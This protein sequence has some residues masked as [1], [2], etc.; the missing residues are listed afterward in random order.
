[1]A[2]PPPQTQEFVDRLTS[3]AV[4]CREELARSSQSIQEIDL[5]I[6]Q[7]QQE[8]DRLSQRE[9]QTNARLRDL[10]ASLE[11]YSR[12]EIRDAYLAAHETQMRLFMMRSQI[13]QLESRRESIDQQQEKLRILLDLAEINREQ[14]EEEL[15]GGEDRT[16]ILPGTQI[17][18]SN[19]D[20][21]AEIVEAREQ[22]RIRI[23]KQLTDGPA[24]VLANV[25]LRAQILARVAER[26]PDQLPAEIEDLSKLV[27]DSLTDVRR[28]IF[29]TRP[30]MLDELGLVQT[31]RRYSADYAREYGA[32]INVD[33]PEHQDEGLQRHA[34]VVLFRLIQQAVVALVQ[35]GAGTQMQINI[36]DEG[37]Q[38]VVRI[39]ATSLGAGASNR[40][41]HFVEDEYINDNLELIGATIQRESI[42]GGER[43]S[44]IMPLAG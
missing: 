25:V 10:E 15:Q 39:D 43:I 40:I 31:L 6:R 18:G 41:G 13:E 37:A 7:T 44:I 19:I 33:G 32:T 11:S 3:L 12:T 26:A 2:L 22:E 30:L 38:M 23:A 36:Q 4:E 16:R 14:S 24:Q 42:S 17:F 8:I 1:M 21:S 35:P 34:R 9:A 29:E 27:T 20:V 5:L 28:A